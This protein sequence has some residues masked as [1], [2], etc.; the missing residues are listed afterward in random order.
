MRSGAAAPP[1]FFDR[2]ANV[3]VVDRL[4]TD[5]GGK[6]GGQADMFNYYSK[7]TL[8]DI[9]SYSSSHQTARDVDYAQVMRN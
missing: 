8:V 9:M 5:D 6:L 7:Y 3:A 2:R 1:P 4:L